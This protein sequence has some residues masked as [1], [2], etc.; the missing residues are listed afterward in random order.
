M[1]KAIFPGSFNP[2]HEGH[3]AIIHKSLK[4]FDQI[5]VLVTFN[6]EKNNKKDVLSNYEKV[7]EN[8]SHLSNVKVIYTEQDLT[9]KIA[10][11]E[12]CKFLIRSARS[13]I[14]FQY[15]LELSAANNS[16][17]KDLETILIIPDYSKI[18]YQSR[19]LK[20]TEKK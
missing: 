7:K 1:K 3:E 9:A 13:N 18:K 11:K 14:D 20:Q 6:P 15:E 12:N 2:F 19:L 5:I 17:N 16:L 8:L 4:L 10:N